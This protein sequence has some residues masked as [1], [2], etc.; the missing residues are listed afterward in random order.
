MM[1]SMPIA[2]PIFIC[3]DDRY[4]FR[5]KEEAERFMEPVDVDPSERGYDAEGRLLQVVVRGK[6]KYGRFGG[7]DQSAARVEL[8]LAEETPHHREELRAVLADWL[9]RADASVAKEKLAEATL[10]ELVERAR[11]FVIDVRP[12][13]SLAPNKLTWLMIV[14][15]ALAWWWW[16]SR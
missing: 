5:S 2:T 11:R 4:V 10:E 12:V 15:L 7:I 1:R 8:V 16:L 3:S 13:P 14:G 6:V 9:A